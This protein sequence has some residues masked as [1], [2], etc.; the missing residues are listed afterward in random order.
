[1]Y[2]HRWY[3]IEKLLNNISGDVS[4]VKECSMKMIETGTD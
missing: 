3:R 1:M 4:L 2:I